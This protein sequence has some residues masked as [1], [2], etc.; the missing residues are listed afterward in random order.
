MSISFGR[1]FC[2]R[3]A[4]SNDSIAPSMA[5]LAG[6]RSRADLLSDWMKSSCIRWAS[7]DCRGLRMLLTVIGPPARGPNPPPPIGVV[8]P[9]AVNGPGP[10]ARPLELEGAG[11]QV[12]ERLRVGR[13]VRVHAVDEAQLV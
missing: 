13:D 1:S 5:G 12:L 7:V 2:M 8:R 9:Q 6:S 10:Q 4:S 11:V 3:K